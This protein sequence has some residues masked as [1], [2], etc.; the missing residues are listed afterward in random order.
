MKKLLPYKLNI[1]LFAEEKVE[2]TETIKALKEEYEKKLDEQKVMYETKIN[3]LN[4]NH[5]EQVRA[6]IS[7]RSENLSEETKKLQETKELSYEERLLKDTRE[8]LG[9]KGGN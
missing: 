6:L 2:E 5:V 4:K 8:K 1:Q 7:G 3:D 9:L